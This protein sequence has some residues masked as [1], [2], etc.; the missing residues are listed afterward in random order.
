MRDLN[1]YIDEGF[2]KSTKT[3]V[4]GI[5][6][7]HTL[8]SV[9]THPEFLQKKSNIFLCIDDIRHGKSRRVLIELDRGDVENIYKIVTEPNTERVIYVESSVVGIP[10]NDEDKKRLLVYIRCYESEHD[11]FWG[12]KVINRTFKINTIVTSKNYINE[13]FYSN[14]KSN[15]LQVLEDF[16]NSPERAEVKRHSGI[17]RLRDI[18][19][20]NT[21]LIDIF[22]IDN[23]C[24]LTFKDESNLTTI[25]ITK[26]KNN[27]R[28][29]DERKGYPAQRAY[30]P[31]LYG[32]STKTTQ[33]YWEN[34]NVKFS[35]FRIEI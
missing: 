26:A 30:F 1:T 17:K 31:T 34:D 19:A 35:N 21:I 12:G 24:E 9:S 29:S 3:D 20:L 10:D 5:L 16:W 33:Y 25:R 8:K 27:Y 22:D 18:G 2:Y 15:P 28:F 4:C 14:V 13:G 6:N 23:V 7:E 32:I 11:V